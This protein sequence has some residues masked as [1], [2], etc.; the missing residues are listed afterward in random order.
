MIKIS[1]LLLAN[2]LLLTTL[3]ACSTMP[4]QGS[5]T[6]PEVATN[7]RIS[8]DYQIGPEDVLEVQVWKNE[9]LS[10]VVTVRPDG[11]ISLPLIGDVPAA[12][13]TAAQMQEAITEKLT[14]YYKDLPPVSVIVQ[15]VRSYVIYVL[16]EVQRPAQYT[17]KRG[18]TLLQAVALAGGFTP[19]AATNNILV[20]RQTMEDH[21]EI[22]LS[23]RYKDI[24]SRQH[25]ESNI[26]LKPGDTIII[27]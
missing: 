26:L 21:N 18:T 4:I 3:F 9:A 10:K 2:A 6:S 17:V 25:P 14:P 22:A 8:A 7:R 27:P 11:K 13:L 23:A 24:V 16:G 20:L 5:L 1:F 12:G 15:E 19:F